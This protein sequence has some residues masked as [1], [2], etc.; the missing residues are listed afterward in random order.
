MGTLAQIERKR[1]D[2]EASYPGWR[3]VLA[4]EWSRDPY[5][6]LEQP[7]GVRTFRQRFLVRRR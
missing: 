4:A 7:L 3:L 2:W 6:T 1:L 5:V